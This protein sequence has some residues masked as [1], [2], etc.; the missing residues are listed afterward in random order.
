MLSRILAG[1]RA[2]QDF[3][4]IRGDLL[5]SFDRQIRAIE[6]NNTSLERNSGQL[7]SLRRSLREA[8]DAA[9]TGE[10][11]PLTPEQRLDEARS[12]FEEALAAFNNPNL[13]E[14]ERY[15]EGSRLQSLGQVVIDL[16]SQYFGGTDRT[17]FD[18]VLSVWNSI[19]DISQDQ[20]DETQ[21]LIDTNN[22]QLTELRRQRE[23]Y[24]RLGERQVASV[25]DLKAQTTA[26]FDRMTASINA[27]TPANIAGV[28]AS[29]LATATTS[30]EI[31]SVVA[32]ARATNN[33]DLFGA[34]L[35]R[36]D[37]LGIYDHAYRSS[38]ETTRLAG[39]LPEDSLEDIA[40]S[41]GSSGYN[42]QFNYD[43]AFQN[44]GAEFEQK[45]RDSVTNFDFSGVSAGELSSREAIA[46][47]GGPA[48][49]TRFYQRAHELGQYYGRYSYA[50]K[51]GQPLYDRADQQYANDAL[52]FLQTLG[53][54]GGWDTNANIFLQANN[55]GSNFD[56]WLR[57]YVNDR[58]GMT[59]YAAGGVVANG[60]WN[61]DSVHAMLA[62]GEYVMPA[63]QVARYMPELEAM[64]SGTYSAGGDDGWYAVCEEIESLKQQN[65][66]L[67]SQLIN[68][69]AMSGEANIE[70]HEKTATALTKQADMERAD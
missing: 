43:L 22:A 16:A 24:E 20:L 38:D 11:S 34:A 5:L 67:M 58:W 61:K 47:E 33:R 35:A 28:Y 1:E 29:Q 52:G 17:D 2:T 4:Q 57:T 53:Y 40:R 44:R 13:S 19:G 70:G 30:G 50:D 31:G 69:T 8:A 55:Y 62:G 23:T 66:Q 51:I 37:E 56:N 39:M 26:A 45:V 68:L 42:R 9:L 64:R 21:Q 32:Y 3:E 18:Y 60:V 12:Q 65:V 36:G 48:S 41:M 54:S 6:D 14:D 49:L 63:P 46:R 59:G 15:R 10:T 25:D 7:I 27:L